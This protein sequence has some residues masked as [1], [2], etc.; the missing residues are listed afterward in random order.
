[1]QMLCMSYSPLNG[2][3]TVSAATEHDSHARKCRLTTVK[4][5]L[6]SLTSR[7][8]FRT[9]RF[10]PCKAHLVCRNEH[11]TSRNR[12]L[13]SRKGHLIPRNGHLGS[14]NGHLIPRNGHFVERN[15]HFVSGTPLPPS[16]NKQPKRNINQTTV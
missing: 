11:F 4:R 2:K 3:N 5:H 10:A 15:G 8:T 7:L 13:G 12:H 16:N 6:I 9:S 1:M 14:R